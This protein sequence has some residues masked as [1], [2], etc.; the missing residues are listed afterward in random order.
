VAELRRGQLVVLVRGRSRR[1]FSYEVF[2]RR[3]EPEVD[4]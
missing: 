4:S 3:Y 1:R 2:Q